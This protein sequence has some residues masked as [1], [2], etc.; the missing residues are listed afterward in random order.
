[1]IIIGGGIMGLSIAYHLQQHTDT[2]VYDRQDEGQATKASAGIICPWASQRRNKLWLDMVTKS[3]K[4]YP[5]FIETLAKVS[6]VDPS[7]ERNGAYILFDDE[8][9]YSKALKRIQKNND[10]YEEMISVS[11][12]APVEYLNNKYYNI[13]V[14]GAMQVKGDAL[15]NALKDAYLKSG[16]T[17]K[18]ESYIPNDDDFKIYATGAYGAEQPF[19]PKVS[20]QKAEILHVKTSGHFEHLPVVMHRSHY[21]VNLSKNHFA[22]GTT[23]IDTES[24]DVTPTK[25]NEEYLLNVFQEFY[26]NIEIV[27]QFMKV[28]LRPYTRDFLPFIGFVDERT[29][30]ANGLGS[31]GLTAAPFLGKVIA[32]TI[33]F[34]DAELDINKYSY[35]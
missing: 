33:I 6:S 24:F 29:F 2:I 7:F 28:G 16:G 3:A 25:E 8:K 20:H 32:D 15:L 19:E 17:I 35:L 11:E 30:V 14:E 31:S 5:E 9:K 12:D 4:Y 26:P 18:N 22:I 21:I 34:N 23:H 13:F 10:V 27:E 1:M